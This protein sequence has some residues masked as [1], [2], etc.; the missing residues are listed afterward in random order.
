MSSG[1]TRSTQAGR[2]AAPLEYLFL[3]LLTKSCKT[4]LSLSP[5]RDET[6]RAGIAIAR[7][8]T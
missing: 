3:N 1:I 7:K 5:A 8:Q 4:R 6:I 2:F